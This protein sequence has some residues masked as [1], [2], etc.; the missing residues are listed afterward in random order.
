MTVIELGDVASGSA[1]RAT[2]EFDA[3]IRRRAGAALLVVVCL[4]TLGG[5]TRP[6]P[7]Q[8]QTRWSIPLTG[9]YRFAAAGGTVVAPTPTG[10]VAAYDL[11]SGRLRWTHPMPEPN[12]A[13]T[14]AAGPGVALL[15]TGRLANQFLGTDGNQY[16]AEYY[17]GTLALDLATGRERWH[18]DG[19]ELARSAAGTIL[20]G[21]LVGDGA[22][23]SAVRMV[24]LR[25]GAVLWTRPES[26]PVTL[27]VAGSDPRR[28]DR[29][30]A[31]GPG[32][33]T[34]VLAWADGRPL[35]AGHLDWQPEPLGVGRTA[36]V[37]AD[38]VN[39]YVRYGGDIG[40][41]LAAYGLTDL[42]P[43]WTADN[44]AE[45]SAFACGRVVCVFEPGSFAAY[46][47][48][49]GR[50]LW[51][52]V[53]LQGVDVAGDRT[54]LVQDAALETWAI[55]DAVTGRS[56]GRPGLGFLVRDSDTDEVVLI[57]PTTDPPSRT[58]VS[59]IDPDTGRQSLRGVVDRVGD[60]GCLLT[61]EHL[62]CGTTNSRLTVARVAP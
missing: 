50:P 3:R 2:P 6:G 36:E 44:A 34:V 25:D 60:L 62:V 20:L 32:G 15:A 41:S 40:G 49:T 39:V 56:R 54:L 43:R 51:R 33:D 22:T 18:A 57:A 48:V 52:Q 30:V 46:D 14:V 53:G 37:F 8:V 24:R 61:A 29:V 11:D 13:P 1:P 28:P 47:P 10:G 27:T 45:V 42:R 35:T 21:D 5:A 16:L 31:V 58:S 55:Y 4:L 59:R 23:V 38:G 7:V 17:R 26:P 19:T 12:S 9:D